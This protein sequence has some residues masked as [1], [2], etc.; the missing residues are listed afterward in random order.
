MVSVVVVFFIIEL[1]YL[2]NYV[3]RIIYREVKESGEESRDQDGSESTPVVTLYSRGHTAST[4]SGGSVLS[5]A[6][7]S[8][9]PSLSCTVEDVLQLLRHLFVI[10]TSLQPEDI[11][12]GKHLKHFLSINEI[13]SYQTLKNVK[14]ALILSCYW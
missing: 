14:I 4:C 11:N 1:I 10:N 5:P 9:L 8:P 13:I 3:Y 12:Y 6:T 2:L 7:P